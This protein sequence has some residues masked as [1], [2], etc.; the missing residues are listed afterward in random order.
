MELCD[1][2]GQVAREGG[3]DGF[4]RPM[5]RHA[6]FFVYRGDTL[7]VGFDEKGAID[8]P[9]P[10]YPWAFQAV[11]KT[12]HSHL[13][14]VMTGAN[15]WFRHPDL[16]QFFNELRGLGFFDCF[17]RVVFYGASMGGYGALAYSAACPGAEVV[18]YSP[19]T[20][21]DPAVVPFET[22]FRDGYAAGDW[23]GAFCDAAEMA[24]LAEKVTVFTDPYH[25]LDAL[26]T[27]RL[28]VHNLVWHKCPHFGHMPARRFRDM[29][30]LGEVSRHAWQGTLDARCFAQ[31]R[32]GARYTSK[33]VARA[34]LRRGVKTGHA[35][36]VV[37]VLD[38]LE[39]SRPDWRF[40]KIRKSAL[41]S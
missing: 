32:R 3:A 28:P 2:Y 23:S 41:L 34:V 39:A 40:P 4:V 12:G 33:K 24:K 13:A 17:K 30:I 8:R 1:R 10:T 26:H 5:T 29:G 20:S 36:L 18:V 6:A 37:R 19:Q 11:K 16:A 31:L 27:R 7:I 25:R 15:D 38:G 35:G 21:L 22:R 14:I 9:A